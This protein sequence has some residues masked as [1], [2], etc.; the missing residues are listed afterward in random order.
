MG[1]GPGQGWSHR[2]LPLSWVGG[3]GGSHFTKAPRGDEHP[4]TLI[5]CHIQSR[6]GGPCSTWAGG[7]RPIKK[8]GQLPDSEESH[9]LLPGVPTC[10]SE[11][12]RLVLQKG[13]HPTGTSACPPPRSWCQGQA[14][15]S[16]PRC[17][18]VLPRQLCSYDVCVTPNQ[19]DN[20]KGEKRSPGAHSAHFRLVYV[21][22]LVL[23]TGTI[24]ASG[25]V[26][27]G[28]LRGLAPQP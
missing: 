13:G 20:P 21:T 11:W 25:M 17:Q 12:R 1:L 2:H 15:L 18:Q 8:P 3:G 14:H 22:S 5:S 23:S 16:A 24:P 19:D 28:W 9:L 10:K 6:A 4:G 26:L 27:E 7:P